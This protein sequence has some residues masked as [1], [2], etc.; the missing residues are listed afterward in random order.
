[1]RTLS[2]MAAR[3]QLQSHVGASHLLLPH[4]AAIVQS[5]A[6]LSAC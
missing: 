3:N 2:L 4:V 1:M 6:G 5:C